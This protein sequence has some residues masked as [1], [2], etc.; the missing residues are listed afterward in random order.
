MANPVEIWKAEKHGLDAWPDVLNYANERTPM[1][2]I[3]TPDLERMKWHGVFYRKRDAPGTYMLRIRLTGCHLT[4]TQARA[5]A[6]VAL[7]Y[8][9]GIVDVTTRANIQIQGLDVEQVPLA[10]ER[11]E[12][13]GL[14]C[15]QT[16]HDNVR[17]VFCHPFSGLDPEE[18][19]DTRTLCEDVTNIFLG[20]RELSNLPRKF[21]I[22]ID[23]Q[24][25][26]AI[27]FWT[28]DI[29]YLATRDDRGEVAFMVLIGGKQGQNPKLAL[30]L[31]VLVAPEDVAPVARALLELFHEKGS[32]EKRDAARFRF[33]VE[34]IGV[35]GVLEELERRLGRP[36][37][38]CVA[39]PTP[40][41]GYED[42]VGWFPQR[43]TGLWIMGLCPPLGR[44]TWRQMEGLA[45][46]SDRWANGQLRTTVEQGIAVVNIPTGFKDAIATDAARVGL[47][48]YADSLVRNMVSCTGKQFCNIAVTETKG[49]A[50][51]LIEKLRQRALTLHGVRIHMSGCPSSCGN[52]HTADIGLK[53]VRVKRLLGTKEGFDVF[54]GG[55]IA[56]RLHM[57]LPFKLGVDVDQLPQLIEEVV[58][59]YYLHQRAGQT[60]SAF[61]REKLRDN[62]AISV[63]EKD[64][65]SAV[66]ECENCRHQHMGE[67]PPIFCPQC[68]ALRR[69]FARL[70]AD[71]RSATSAPS[72]PISSC[73]VDAEGFA[74]ATDEASIRE[75]VGKL[76]QI[77]GKEIALFRV[78]GKVH[79]V[80][81]VCPHAGGSLA[82][83]S[84]QDGV[85]AC[86]MHGWTF[87]VRTGC[88][89]EPKRA[90]VA[91]YETRVA[92]GQ[93]LVLVAPQAGAP[94][95]S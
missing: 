81:G 68:A 91:S 76:V 61:W 37:R 23:G 89:V 30:H 48:V 12:A 34:K 13:T 54:L 38:P 60:F 24:S 88:G 18:L 90:S 67:D 93:V 78:E 35:G 3:P 4:S 50:L 28:Q 33:L 41:S 94:V 26:H 84:C 70:D 80:D 75:G 19:I 11:L 74:V 27:H 8:G 6:F 9:Y 47:S 57:G 10:I 21:N 69:F 20:D 17:N 45:I 59:E 16:G 63:D 71:T 14:T 64:Y 49:H 73:E 31:P 92:N 32:R 15:K 58:H 55:G 25:R 5:I 82:E 1:K 22:G 83:G 87:D 46:A 65:Q 85:V 40:P 42:L 51:Q 77:A 72:P 66:W 86:P 2:Q 29:S 79:A 7:E 52:H 53:G 44:L 36:L 95:R 43:Q 56:G 39:E 62:E